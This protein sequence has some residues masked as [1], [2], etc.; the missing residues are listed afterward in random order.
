MSAL[1]TFAKVNKNF[2]NIQTLED[3]SFEI[4]EG[5]FVFIVGAS[6]AGKTTIL[7]LLLGEY[8]PSNGEIVVDGKKL[9]TLSRREIP[10]YR[11]K[12]GIVFQD[13]KLLNERTVREN[14]EIPLAV[15]NVP[16][17]EWQIR[18]DK[19][20]ELVGLSQRAELFPSQLSGGE[21]QRVAIARA[22]VTNPKFIFA[23]EPTGNLDWET[24]DQI[25]E[26]LARINKEGKT[27]IVTSHH[28]SLIEKLKKRV[29]EM[30]N[31]KIVTD[32]GSKKENRKE[33]KKKE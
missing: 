30:K 11:Q 1:I 26:L 2:G 21:V 32:S 25:M 33:D 20:L 14:I 10:G 28:K 12:I 16:E 8:K 3:I 27:V 15:K 4:Y 31:G 29:V 9:S 23:D 22:L 18:V 5:E 13:F 19:I 24:A 7:K 6:G 17:P